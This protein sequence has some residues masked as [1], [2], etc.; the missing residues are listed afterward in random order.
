DGVSPMSIPGM[1]GGM[2][3]TNGLEH[4]ER[5]RPSSMYVV[6][7][8]MN[9]KRYRKLTAIAKKFRLYRRF[10]AENPELGILCWG[11]SMGPVREAIDILT[12]EGIRV[13]AFVPRILMPLPAADIQ[14]FVDSCSQTLVL[15][16]SHSAQFHQFLRT[17]IDLPR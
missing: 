10:G 6:H 16:L 1:A 13:A 8:R 5:G 4:D 14:Q 11:S 17:E 2:Y 9:D 3:Q 12:M 7:E 15:E